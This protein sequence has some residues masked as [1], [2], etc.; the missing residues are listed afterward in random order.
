MKKVFTLLAAMTLWGLQVADAR[1]GDPACKP[2][3]TLTTRN[4]I[5]EP[6]Q[7]DAMPMFFV[8]NKGQIR[9]Q[10]GQ[11]RN[12]I[13]FAVTGKGLRIFI[14]K[15]TMHYQFL[16]AEDG[17]VASY[18][19]DVALIG[20][21]K[22]ATLVTGEKLSF[23]EQYYSGKDNIAA[24]SFQQITY[25][26]VYPGIDWV[27]YFNASGKLEHDFIIH[28]GGK[29]SD[30]RIQYNGAAALA[31]NKDGSLTAKTPMGAIT[32]AAPHSYILTDDVHK[33]SVIASSF[34]L[35]KNVLRFRTAAHSGTLVIDPA[36]EWA[37]YYGGDVGPNTF[38]ATTIDKIT[39][40]HAGNVY[41]GGRAY[42][43]NNIATTGSYQTILDGANNIYIAKFSPSGT[44][45]WGTYY[46]SEETSLIGD[47]TCDQDNNVYIT[48]KTSDALPGFSTPGSHQEI[49][50]SWAGA[51]LIKFSGNGNRLWA[52]YYSGDSPTSGSRVATDPSG[53]VYM[54][55]T[56]FSTTG[57]ATPGSHKQSLS[58][59]DAFLVKF[60][61]SGQRIW[62][63]YYGSDVEFSPDHVTASYGGLAC[64]TGGNVYIAGATSATAGI[65]FGSNVHQSTYGG[66]SDPTVAAGDGFLAKL[67]SNGQVLWGTYYGGSGNDM[68][69]DISIDHNANIYMT[70]QT[71]SP[72]AMAT[73]G[74]YKTTPGNNTQGFLH[75]IA[76]FNTLGQRQWGTYYG[77]FSASTLWF[78]SQMQSTSV[79]A[80]GNLWVAGI[81]ESDSGFVSANGLNTTFS[82]APSPFLAK[83]NT[84]NGF[85]VWGT[86][87]GD[88]QF[89]DYANVACDA[90]G[91]VYF[92]S[93]ALTNGWATPG[94][95]QVAYLTNAQQM[96]LLV[97]FEDCDSVLNAIALP[98]ILGDTLLCA[99]ST[100]TFSIPDVASSYT[101]TLPTGWTGSSTTDSIT[102]TA[103]NT[104]GVISVSGNFTCGASNTQTLNVGLYPA[105]VPVI[106]RNGSVLS[107]GSFS[108]YQWRKDGQVI[109]NATGSSIIITADGSYTVTVTDS[110]GCKA[111]SAVLN[112]TGLGIGNI[113]GI[114]NQIRLYPNPTETVLHISAPVKINVGLYSIDGRQLQYWE[115]ASLMDLSK[116]PD[117]IYLLKITDTEGR[118]LKMDKVVKARR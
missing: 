102:V 46:G 61:S 73:A 92:S 63:T 59:H 22:K 79:D 35:D 90:F 94:S 33:N 82:T 96:A 23:F 45:L 112:V 44:R 69:A 113:T 15:G 91:N 85:P 53:N 88:G 81:T 6:V 107:T 84:G 78:W 11:K 58:N 41:I 34:V 4:E 72:N 66:H 68:V 52:T 26:E 13:D 5:R 86:Y 42:A 99:G 117:G 60:N 25:K 118:L 114:G 24:G 115:L 56:T 10:K 31:I 76:K 95:H 19:M 49:L 29:V 62:G 98:A 43:S 77:E 3:H 64:D 80:A 28:P 30:I 67:D 106:S 65:A 48:G 50:T 89:Y 74:A 36:V 8:E 1:N 83:I 104:P 16:K 108:S 20:A 97:K 12:D 105:P 47:M 103:G 109:T 17:K 75:F 111:T 116:L 32:E 39:T 27:F 57:I 71:G 110:N 55:G 100:T 7:N 87:F 14:G 54:L 101:W 40:D 21:N 51:F 70:G 18:R 9:D 93:D 2:G 37:T 38:V